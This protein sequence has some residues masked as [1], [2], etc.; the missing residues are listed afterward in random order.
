MFYLSAGDVIAVTIAL[1]LSLV[2]IVSTLLRNIQLQAQID[3]Y[4]RVIAI[5]KASRQAYDNRTEEG[6]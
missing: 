3:N 2:L 1:T 4:R 6:R 5:Q